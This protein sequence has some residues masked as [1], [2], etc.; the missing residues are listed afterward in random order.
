M[1]MKNLQVKDLLRIE[2]HKT[3][4]NNYSIWLLI[5]K[6]FEVAKNLRYQW[7]IEDLQSYLELV[8]NE[9][10]EV[11]KNTIWMVIIDDFVLDYII[12]KM[13]NFSI[14]MKNKQTTVKDLFTN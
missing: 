12:E 1:K 13:Y 4:K 11:W 6:R 5:P 7:N 2:P 8:V 10:I 9:I 3:E 14:S